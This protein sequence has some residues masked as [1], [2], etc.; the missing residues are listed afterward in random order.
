V[1]ILRT[2]ISDI[3]PA[4]VFVWN[5]HTGVCAN[6]L[7]SLCKLNKTTAFYMERSLLKEGVFFDKEGVNGFSSLCN[8][9]TKSDLVKFSENKQQYISAK[10]DAPKVRCSNFSKWRKVI[11]LPLQ[12]QADTNIL[13]FS[14][15]IKTM[16]SLVLN[17]YNAISEDTLLVV[18]HH[19]EEVEKQ[20]NLPIAN[21]IMYSNKESLHYW[22]GLS[23]L[24]VTINSTVGF[25]ALLVGSP[26]LTF[27][28]SIYSG[29]ELCTE[30]GNLE[31]LANLLANE[32]TYVAPAIEL[33]QQYA[34]YLIYHHT[35]L[36]GEKNKAIENE[37]PSIMNAK[38]PPFNSFKVSP[39][40]VKRQAETLFDRLSLS[41]RSEPINV[42]VS[43]DASHTLNLTYRN[44]SIEINRNYIDMLLK[45]RFG[46]KY[47]F[48]IELTKNIQQEH[49]IKVLVCSREKKLSLNGRSTIVMDKYSSLH[50]C[51]Y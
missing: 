6:T 9:V 25:E 5:G 1:K 18:R 14:D 20:L 4:A 41:K 43:L 48:N 17:I 26:V 33:V 32:S 49:D 12:V 44:N 21:N 50:P 16:R 29:K 36:S 10:N 24:V 45:N 51:Q 37:F 39:A 40:S 8:K 11:F 38:V 47:K 13:L 34:D 3:K 30:V 27:G 23:D 28:K 2:V 22:I 46:K 19:P 35:A 31:N 15:N 42:G 7:R